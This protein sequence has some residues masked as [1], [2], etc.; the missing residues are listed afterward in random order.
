MGSFRLLVTQQAPLRILKFVCNR[1]R[2]LACGGLE[3]VSKW[4]PSGVSPEVCTQ[5]RVAAVGRVVFDIMHSPA[6][7]GSWQLAEQFLLPG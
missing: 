2:S 5:L 1:I 4:R 7:T 6:V 3:A